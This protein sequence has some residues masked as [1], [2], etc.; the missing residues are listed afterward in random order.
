MG[1]HYDWIV[2]TH[3]SLVEARQ[4]VQTIGNW[5]GKK[6]TCSKEIAA[7]Q[8]WIDPGQM[9]KPAV[10]IITKGYRQF[11]PQV[12]KEVPFL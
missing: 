2:G 9:E 4:F 10:P 5:Q 8:E 1:R 7:H 3:E 11:L 6:I 12:G